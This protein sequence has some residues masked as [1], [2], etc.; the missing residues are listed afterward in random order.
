[1][2]DFGYGDCLLSRIKMEITFAMPSFMETTVVTQ[3]NKPI[4]KFNITFKNRDS[5]SSTMKAL[6]NET[7]IITQR[8]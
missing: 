2:L 8:S 7:L 6:Y 4:L 5:L 1:M 3:D